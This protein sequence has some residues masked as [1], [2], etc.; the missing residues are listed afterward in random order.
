MT[1][2]SSSPRGPAALGLPGADRGGALEGVVVV[3]LAETLAG[4]FAG[5]PARRP[6]RHRHQG[7]ASRGLAAPEARPGPSRGG[8]A[9]L[10]VGEPRQVLGAW[11]TLADL[12]G[13]GWLAPLLASADA[14]VEDLGPGRLEAAGLSPDALH[15]R[16]PRLA[17]L[18]ISPFGQTGPLA[19]ERGDDRIAQAFSGVQFTTGFP[20]R[21]PIPVTLPLLDCWTGVHGSQWPPDGD[22]PRAPQRP[23]AGRRHRPLP[24]RA[25]HA[26]GGRRPASSDRR[27]GD[28]H[29]HRVGPRWFPP[30][31]IRRATAGG[32]RCPAP[33]TSRSCGSARRS[34]RPT[35]PRIRGSPRP[36]RGCRTAPPPTSSSPRGSPARSRRGRGALLRL[37][38]RGHRRSARS[39][40]SS[41]TSTSWRAAICCRSRRRA[42]RTSSRP[43]RCRSS[44]ARRRRARGARPRLGEHTDAV[45]ASVEAIATRARVEAPPAAETSPWRRPR[46]VEARSPASASSTSPSGSRDRWPRRS[47]P[48][49]APTSIMV[50]LPVPVP[51]G[52]RPALRPSASPTGTSGASRSTCGRR[53]GAALFLDLARMSDVIVENF[54]PGTL[55]RWDLAPP[56]LLEIN[57]RLVILRASGFGQ[58]GPYAARAAFNPVGLAFGGATYL[59]GWPDRPPLRDGVTAGDYSTALFNALGDARRAASPRRGRARAGR[60]HRHVRGRAAHDRRCARRAQRARHPPRARR[61]R[62]ARSTR[63][64]SPSRPRTAASSPCQARPGTT[65]PPPSTRLGRPR[66]DDPARGAPGRLGDRARAR[67]PTRRRARPARGRALREHGEL[68]GGPGWRGAPLEPRRPRQGCRS[69]SSARS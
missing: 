23:W 64:A 36:P 18:R 9:L 19:G 40:T 33:A 4:E 15:A 28:A 3:E 42:A 41:R 29:G 22:L 55:E 16:N 53:A 48:S 38:R 1:T 2:E 25:A 51:R 39:T 21:P 10:P 49:S 43:R 6:R 35:R 68:G 47:W 45:R 54:R 8:L 24:G 65:S 56:T 58:T 13:D 17:I 27:R 66:S 12:A 63:R 32:S 20:D 46:E 61:R 5:G 7:R 37:R 69:R 52:A 14:L 26:G 50:E 34:R 30:M 62:A 59:N 67:R 57:P 31:S 11:P 60:R 44:R